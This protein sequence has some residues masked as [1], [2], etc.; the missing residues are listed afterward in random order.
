M[1]PCRAWLIFWKEILLYLCCHGSQ[2]CEF[3]RI[4][5]RL[6][7]WTLNWKITYSWRGN[8]RC[9]ISDTWV[10]L[11]GCLVCWSNYR[12]RNEDRFFL[13][14]DRKRLKL[15]R[16]LSGLLRFLKG[17]FSIAFW[18]N[19][20]DLK[21]SLGFLCFLLSCAIDELNRGISHNLSIFLKLIHMLWVRSKSPWVIQVAVK[22]LVHTLLWDL[23]PLFSR[24]QLELATVRIRKFSHWRY[25]LFCET[26]IYFI[27]IFKGCCS[28]LFEN[29]LLRCWGWMLLF[30]LL[31]Q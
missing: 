16:K 12:L 29:W 27:V 4:I 6:S 14:F 8:L 15:A 22:G 7:C 28:L 5:H 3:V 13:G 17:A 31:R 10:K 2:F 21:V 1:V 18:H 19:F 26:T 23:L 24:F 9:R 20:E 30:L 25:L 11:R